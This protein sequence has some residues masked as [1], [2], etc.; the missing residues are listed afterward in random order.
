[1][2]TQQTGNTGEQ[3]ARKCLKKK[4]YHILAE[5]WHCQYGELDIIA[6]QGQTIVFVEVKTRHGKNM[7]NAFAA[8]TPSKRKKLITSA[9][10]YLSEHHYNDMA[11]RI[12]AIGITLHGRHAPQIVHVED[13]LDW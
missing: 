8:I 6:Q 7:T 2:G 12:D 4:G 9:Q 5:N 13:A 10:L 11:W 1:M 3:L